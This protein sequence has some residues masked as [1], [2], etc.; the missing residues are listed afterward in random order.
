M[1]K[2]YFDY[3]NRRDYP[4]T[5]YADWLASDHTPQTAHDPSWMLPE[6]RLPGLFWVD[7]LHRKEGHNLMTYGALF[8]VGFGTEGPM[9]QPL[10]MRIDGITNGIL[11][12]IRVWEQTEENL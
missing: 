4:V 8:G 7:T 9:S 10:A 12:A 11:A 6:A 5:D 2:A 1:A 3:I